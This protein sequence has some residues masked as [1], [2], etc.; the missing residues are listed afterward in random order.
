MLTS[1][2]DILLTGAVFSAPYVITFTLTGAFIQYTIILTLQCT[3]WKDKYS[4]T[5]SQMYY[6]FYSLKTNGTSGY[7]YQTQMPLSSVSPYSH[8][9]MQS[10]PL[11][12]NKR[13]SYVNN[14]LFW[15]LP[16]KVMSLVNKIT[17]LCSK[18]CLINTRNMCVVARVNVRASFVFLQW[19][20]GFSEIETKGVMTKWLFTTFYI[21]LW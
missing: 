2:F 9:I 12:E 7:S 15:C 21:G 6:L 4:K 14:C 3:I 17:Q 19:A 13:Y 10:G 11:E 5:S 16:C 20:L 8:D 1:F 18:S